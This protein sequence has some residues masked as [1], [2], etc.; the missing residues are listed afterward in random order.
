MKPVPIFGDGIAGKSL[1][2]TAQRRVNVLFENRPDGDKTKV[3]VIGT[4]GLIGRDLPFSVAGG[5]LRGLFGLGDRLFGVTY[6]GF[7]EYQGPV[8][9]LTLVNSYPILTIGGNVSFDASASQVLMVDGSYGYVL[10]AGV[11]TQ[12][13]SPGFPNGARTIAFV[14]GRFVA[15]QPGTQQ[16]W[17]S[18]SFDGSTWNALA[19]ASASQYAGTLLAVDGLNGNLIL[20][21]TDHVEFWQN[22]NAGVE[23][24]APIQAATDEHGLAAIFSRA[25]VAGSLFFVAQL[26]EGGVQVCRITGYSVTVIS[27]PD[28]DDIIGRYSTVADAVGM[29]W[30]YSGHPVYQVTF[31]TGDRTFLYDTTTGIWT[32]RQSGLTEAEAT[33]HLGDFAATYRGQVLITGGGA[34]YSQDGDTFTDDGAVILRE[35]V[36]RH[37]SSDFN[38]FTIDEAYL[39]METGVGNR[40]T[41]TFDGITT[42]GSGINPQVMMQCSKDNGRTWGTERW[43]PLG[44]VG[45]YETR[46]LWDQWGSARDFVFRI[47]MTDPV[48]FVITAGAITARQGPP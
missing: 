7:N 24:F 19:F 33:R 32:E 5:T 23:P 38:D 3:A 36:T 31:P 37:A 21:C 27:T 14:S 30:M 2:I 45:E 17:V 4:P 22:V 25:H 15:E 34:F 29:G 44:R 43:Q 1:V 11:L 40:Q 41:S 35:L 12:I 13:T 42:L 8:D 26:R 18:D 48:K 10:Q 47:R 46:V 16:F 28:M 39:D 9:A 20:M 6:N